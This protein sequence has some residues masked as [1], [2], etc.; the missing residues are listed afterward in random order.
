MSDMFGGGSS[1]GKIIKSGTQ[2]TLAPWQSAVGKAASDLLVK[3]LKENAG[4][5][6]YPSDLYPEVPDLYN[7][8]YNNYANNWQTP[9]ETVNVLK[10]AMKGTPLYE[11]DPAKTTSQWRTTYA[12][13]MMETWKETVAPLLKES[14]NM[15]GVSSSRAGQAVSDN[16][17]QFYN[18]AV[19]PTLFNA[20][21]NAES[22]GAQSKENAIQ[23][24][25][26]AAASYG[27]LPF[28]EFTNASQA[29]LSN[30][31]L[32]Q[33]RISADF[34]E[35]LRTQ[36]EYSNY[37]NLGWS[38]VTVSPTIANQDIG[39]V[40]GTSGNASMGML[41]ALGMSMMNPIASQMGGALASSILGGFGGSATSS[42][43]S[44]LWAPGSIASSGVVNAADAWTGAGMGFG[45]W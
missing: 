45:M 22:M 35:W 5:T 10:E 17:S 43:A 15:S 28:S 6:P 11:Y 44:G 4:N 16:A 13:P 40:P 39:Y 30:Y 31:Q 8:A 23:R 34:N 36:P 27:M 32:G 29:A 2:S 19:G 12:T 41:G 37:L 26:A 33:S 42:A 20:L 18:Q 1:S 3:K 9:P 38:G 21:Q 14:Y 7:E 25:M 24:Q